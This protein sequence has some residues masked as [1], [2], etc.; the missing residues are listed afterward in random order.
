MISSIT[1]GET[2]AAGDPAA[3]ESVFRRIDEMQQADMKRLTPDPVDYYQPFI[4][5][6]LS[7]TGVYLLT[8][9]G[10]RYTPW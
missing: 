6:I 10:L 9:F 5:T 1:G 4:I 3:L 8:L 7:L 2:F